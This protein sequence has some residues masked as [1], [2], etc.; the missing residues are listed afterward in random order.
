[1]LMI[2]VMPL[3]ALMN[4]SFSGR[5]VGQHEVALDAAEAD[6]RAG[7]RLADEVGRDLALLDELRRDADAA[8]VAV[9]VGGQRVGAPV[10][11]AV[12]DDA[13]PQVLAGLVAR[14]LVAR[15]DHDRH[16]VAGL[17][18][19]ALDPAAQLARRPERVDQLEVVVGQQRREQR[20]HG[21]QRAPAHRR[22]LGSCASLRH[23]AAP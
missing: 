13:D 4:S 18:L 1:M 22:D 19:D 20:P 5:R 21:R 9:G 8:V 2:G 14:P 11:I 16:R 17:G 12:D 23:G 15:P 3:P 6:D 7:L 10:G